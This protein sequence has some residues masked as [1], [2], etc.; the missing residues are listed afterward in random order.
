MSVILKPL[1]AAYNA[2]Y[3]GLRITDIE[4]VHNVASMILNDGLR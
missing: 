1:Y 2:A 3:N 4:D